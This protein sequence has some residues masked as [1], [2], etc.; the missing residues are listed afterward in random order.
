MALTDIGLKL[1]A[2]RESLG[3]S[4]SDISNITKIREHYI[5]DI[6]NGD[7]SS[8]SPIYAKSFVEAYAKAV[9]LDPSEYKSEL[10][11]ETA[12]MQAARPKTTPKSEESKKT[13]K[14]VRLGAG[15]DSGSPL[16][17][18]TTKDNI[19]RIAF[20]AIIVAVIVAVYTLY[21][22]EAENDIEDPVMTS[23]ETISDTTLIDI[24]GA[25]D[26]YSEDESEGLL[27][28]VFGGRDSIELEARAID[29]SWVKI[30]MDG[31]RVD[32]KLIVP[33]QTVKWRAK[34]RF[35][36]T[37][38]NVGALE[39]RRNGKLLEPFGPRGTVVK[40]V[41]ITAKEVIIK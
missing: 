13:I 14:N 9:K 15:R 26:D 29:S 35:V 4:S 10:N 5:E 30:K 34:E 31:I 7:L 12:K 36:L 20:A 25:N 40:D 39:I 18:I 22:A 11:A 16:K 23:S 8:I 37:Q 24:D 28:G 6:E 17:S 3:L 21:F 19:T 33:G 27:S 41:E 32:E 1:K 2:A 38:G